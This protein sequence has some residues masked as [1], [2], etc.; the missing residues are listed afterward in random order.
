MRISPCKGCAD[1]VLAC[2]GKCE[3]YKK[4]RKGLDELNRQ[5]RLAKEATKYPVLIFPPEDRE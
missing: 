4:W 1:R 5:S 3:K 2:H